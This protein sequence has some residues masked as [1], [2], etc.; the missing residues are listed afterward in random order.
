ME[1]HTF[2]TTA[3]LNKKL[4]IFFD[5]VQHSDRKTRKSM[6]Q[7]LRMRRIEE[8]ARSLSDWN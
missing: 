1:I 5:A 7:A 2:E 3:P 6:I 4:R 8:F